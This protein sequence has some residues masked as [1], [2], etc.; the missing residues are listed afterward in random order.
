MRNGFKS[1]WTILGN[2]VLLV[3]ILGL[4]I[5]YPFIASDLPSRLYTS[6]QKAFITQNYSRNINQVA[7]VWNVVRPDG[8]IVPTILPVRESRVRATLVAHYEEQERLSVTLYDLDFHAEY[9]LVNPDCESTTIELFFPFPGNLETLHDVEFLVDGEEPQ[10]T[11]FSTGGIVWQAEL[12][13]GEQHQVTISY[14][15]DGATSFTYG[16]VHEQRSDVDVVITVAGLTGSSVSNA[17][18]PPTASVVSTGSETFTWDYD[19]LIA[20]RDIQLTLP[21]QLSFVQRVTYL[22]DDFRA[23]AAIAPFLVGLFLISMA[24]ILQLSGT[25]LQLQGYLLI[26]CGMALFYPLLTFSSGLINILIAA[27]LVMLLVSAMLL[28][29]LRLLPGWQEIRWRASGLI[30]IFLGVFSLG[31]LTPWRGL[32]FSG[33]GLLLIGVFMLAYATR[34]LP[35]QEPEPIPAPQPIEEEPETVLHHCPS[36]GFG[37]EDGYSY[38]PGCGYDARH[39]RKCDSCG[40][41]QFISSETVQAHCFYCGHLLSTNLECEQ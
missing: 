3:T 26:G 13:Q 24:G 15:A 27:P 19:G 30:F 23:L 28:N 2:A 20:N 17:F 9:L 25:R 21:A 31:M 14:K 38:C 10:N 41:L 32:F 33:G 37:L 39:F 4:L 36:C 6:A 5:A 11:I 8:A 7:P 34:S 1:T 29:F 35:E 40:S 16:L 22:Q 12:E 18:L